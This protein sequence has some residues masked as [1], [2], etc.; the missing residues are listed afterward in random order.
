MYLVYKR[1]FRLSCRTPILLQGTGLYC[2][3]TKLHEV[4]KL[5]E[6]TKLHENKTAGLHKVARSQN[7]TKPNFYEG[8]KLHKVNLAQVTFL[9][10]SKKYRKKNKMKKRN[11][12]VTDRE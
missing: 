3:K 2:T 10:E 7:C 4:T 5:H 1:T 11:K 6:R 12:N 8:T 9:H